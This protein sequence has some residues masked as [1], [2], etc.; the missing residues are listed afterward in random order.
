MIYIVIHYAHKG[1]EYKMHESNLLLVF[2]IDNVQFFYQYWCKTIGP[3][4]VSLKG[5]LVFMAVAAMGQTSLYKFINLK[6]LFLFE[7][8]ALQRRHMFLGDVITSTAGKEDLKISYYV[9]NLTTG[10]YHSCT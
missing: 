10:N 7:V 6:K 5:V 8:T 9:A 4:I 1:L 3:E 2:K